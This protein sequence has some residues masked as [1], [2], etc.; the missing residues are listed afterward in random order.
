MAMHYQPRTIAFHCEL[1]HPA[2]QPD[3]AAIQRLHNRLFQSG[4][5]AYRNF[6]VTHEGAVLSNPVARPG[7][8]SHAAF[9][10]DRFRFAEEH[11]ALTVEDFAERVHAIAS[12]VVQEVGIQVFTAQV[13]TVRT[14]VNPRHFRDGRGFLRQGLLGLDS[15]PE[16]FGRP[17]NGLGLRLVFPPTPHHPNAFAVRVESIPQ[18][19][20]SL[21]LE[22]I[23]TFPPLPIA[24]GLDAVREHVAQTYAFAVSNVL[25]FLARFDA[26]E[27]AEEA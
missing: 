8:A 14:L 19:P 1:L 12:N 27:P 2:V 11:T 18:D 4:E 15:E 16:E 10:A 13:V 22:N 24:R 21:F 17:A 23:G 6:A 5:P 9:L 3:V 25:R 7:A 26:P 20:R